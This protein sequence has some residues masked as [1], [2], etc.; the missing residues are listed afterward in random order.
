MNSVA[1]SGPAA[2][3]IAANVPFQAIR[4]DGRAVEAHGVALR[5][6]H[7]H[8]VPLGDQRQPCAAVPRPVPH[9]EHE[10]RRFRLALGDGG[11]D[12]AIGDAHAAAEVLVA[13]HARTSR[14]GRVDSAVHGVATARVRAMSP[15]LPGSEVIVPHCSPASALKHGHRPRARLVVGNLA[16]RVA[17]DEFR[18]LLRARV[19]AVAFSF[20]EGGDVHRQ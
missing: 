14:P 20:D 9:V 6:L 8:A 2:A 19:R 7:P 11:R 16:A 3:V 17:A 15:P 10:D 18:D 5:R 12:H 13:G 4:T 1:T